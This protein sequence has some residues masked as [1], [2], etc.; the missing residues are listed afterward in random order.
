MANYD[1]PVV[2]EISNGGEELMCVCGSNKMIVYTVH[3]CDKCHHN[4]YYLDSDYV[5]Q[6]EGVEDVMYDY[7]EELRLK[8]EEKFGIKLARDQARDEGVCFLGIDT[9]GAGCTINICAECGS[10]ADAVAFVEGC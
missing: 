8:A 10:F 5:A 7:D 6:L 4:G 1:I 3:S 2:K 9:F